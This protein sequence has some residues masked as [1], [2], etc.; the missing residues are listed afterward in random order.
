MGY[1]LIVVGGGLGGAALGCGMAA[2]GARVLIVEREA[3][4]RD[5]V[6]GEVMLPWG[7]TEARA[8]GIDAPVRAAGAHEIR[9]WRSADA[10]RG[11][12]QPRDVPATTPHG[13][14]ALDFYHPQMQEAVVQAAAAAGAEVRR[15]VAIVGVTPGTRPAV[16]VAGPGGVVE[17][18]TARLVVGADG[19]ASRVRR[20]AGFAVRHDPPCLLVSGVLFTGMPLPDDGAQIMG[21]PSIGQR[22]LIFPLGDGRYR[23]Y[24]VHR[25][26]GSLQRLSGR[27]QVPAFVDA[28]RVT[29]APAEWVAGVEAVG[30][31]ATFNGADSWVDHP[32]Q[33]GVALIGDAAAT[34]DPSYGCGLSL[35]VRDARV[36]RDHLL[37]DDDWAAAGHA[38]AAEHDRYYAALHRIEGW[39]TDLVYGMG[40]EAD[41]RRA[42][43]FPRLAEERERAPDIIGLGPDGPNSDEDLQPFR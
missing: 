18:V 31:L 39:L 41:A 7:V 6:R 29:G 32:Y 30:P 25:T 22:L 28:C 35:T 36:L 13:T 1:D 27:G 17:T 19:R 23:T 8:L 40:P 14:G 34:S 16:Q 3:H 10:V 43:V 26:D 15:G 33:D 24:L 5:R 21:H 38:Y 2:A 42:R 20:W 11:S 12:S 4:F 9:W 37:A